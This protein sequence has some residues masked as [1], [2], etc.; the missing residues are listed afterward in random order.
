MEIYGCAMTTFRCRVT[1]HHRIFQSRR[2][3]SAMG[4]SLRALVC[5]SVTLS[6]F[7]HDWP[8]IL[9][10]QRNGTYDGLDLAESWPKE[11]PPIVWQKELGHGFSGPV[12]AAGKVLVFHRRD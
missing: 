3:F 11:G 10:P 4:R 7:A 1:A 5:L 8:Q 2:R 12:V 6:C 9:G